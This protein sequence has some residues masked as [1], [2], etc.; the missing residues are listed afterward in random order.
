MKRLPILT[1]LLLCSCCLGCTKSLQ[2]ATNEELP[3]SFKGVH[4]LVAFQPD[5]ISGAKPI[6]TEGFES[7]ANLKVRT[8]VCVDGV[9][10]DIKTAEYFGI[11]TIHIPLKYEA[12]S[13]KQILDLTTAVA[14]GRKRG[15]VYIHCHQGKHRSAA[16]AAIV[17][18]A[19]GDLTIPQAKELMRVSQTSAVYHGLWDAV[20][21][22]EIRNVEEILQNTTIFPSS[23]EPK[24]ITSQMIAIDEALTHLNLMQGAAWKAPVAHP[25]L[26]GAAEAGIIADTFR[27]MQVQQE[28]NLYSVDFETLL[29]NAIQHAS[30]L[31]EALVEALPNAALDNVMQRVERSCIHC[32]TLFRK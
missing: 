7:L 9:P 26:V 31:E 2:F 21:R 29:V 15:V 5:I 20:E 25:D 10:P 17:S 19:F 30:S 11:K 6:G 12:P 1:L 27:N 22:T 32:H 28:A 14:R 23:V 3:K 16:A 8:I 4:Q 24:G 13:P 18:V